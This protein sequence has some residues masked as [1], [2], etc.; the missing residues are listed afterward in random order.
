MAYTITS[1]TIAGICQIANTDSGMTQPGASS[2]TSTPPMYPGMIVQAFDPTYGQGEFIWLLGVASTAVG[3]VVTY[4]L[5]TF[6]TTLAPIG[7]N[8]PQPIAVAM[9]ATGASTWGWYQIGGLAVAKKQ[10]ATATFTTGVALGVGATGVFTNT[11]TGMEVQGA[12][13]AGGATV[14]ASTITVILNR[15]HMQGRIT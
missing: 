3:S 6:A 12:L 13:T 9:A 11:F 8:L 10:Q 15:P 5:T 1:P 2:A 14:S 4:N 7:A